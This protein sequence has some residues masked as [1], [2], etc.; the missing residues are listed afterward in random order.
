MGFNYGFE[1]RKFDR[2]WEKL[3]REYIEA[4]MDEATIL[5]MYEFDWEAFK[6]ERTGCRSFPAGSHTVLSRRGTGLPAP[7]G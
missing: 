6:K 1:K 3:Y 2:V 7:S 4:G 5:A